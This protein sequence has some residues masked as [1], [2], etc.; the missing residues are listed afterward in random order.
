[1]DGDSEDSGSYELEELIHIGRLE[2]ELFRILEEMLSVDPNAV[3][4][5]ETIKQRAY[6]SVVSTT[7]S[8]VLH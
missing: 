3:M 2:Q 7:T 1:M 5:I 6:H 4:R 8:P